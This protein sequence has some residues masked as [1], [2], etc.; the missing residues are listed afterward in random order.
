VSGVQE[1]RAASRGHYGRRPLPIA[2]RLSPIPEQPMMV[3]IEKNGEQTG[4]H[5]ALLEQATCV[6][7]GV[8]RCE[9]RI[10]A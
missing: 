10:M 6:R 3:M 4:G 2:R 7:N 1:W 5:G 8:T 9:Q